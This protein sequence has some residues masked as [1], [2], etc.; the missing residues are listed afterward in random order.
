[1]TRHTRLRRSCFPGA[2][3]MD[4]GMVP[5]PPQLNDVCDFGE[6]LRDMAQKVAEQADGAGAL[7]GGFAQPLKLN[8]A[9]AAGAGSGVSEVTG[10]WPAGPANPQA[11]RRAGPAQRLEYVPWSE[12]VTSS[13]AA[14]VA[15][16]GP[17]GGFSSAVVHAPPASR[18]TPAVKIETAGG[19][20]ETGNRGPVKTEDMTDDLIHEAMQ[21]EVTSESCIMI[22]LINTQLLKLLDEGVVKYSIGDRNRHT[23]SKVSLFLTFYSQHTWGMTLQHFRKTASGASRCSRSRT[24][25]ASTRPSEKS[26]RR[27]VAIN[28]CSVRPR[29][30]E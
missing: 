30:H 9:P 3:A 11:L 8:V 13:A 26:H 29:S 17:A 19:L 10:A 25:C 21:V 2:S 1:V 12:P 5:P 18:A 14:S 4:P 15:A 22:R 7:L 27:P 28:P 24:R 20:G 16:G 23:F 6:V